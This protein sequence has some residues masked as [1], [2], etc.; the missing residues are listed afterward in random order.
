[1]RF[2]IYQDITN[3]WRWRIREADNKTVAVSNETYKDKQD[4]L[5]VINLIKANATNLT[6]VELCHVGEQQP[7]EPSVK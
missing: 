5:N 1:M 7:V 6:V 2:E 4:C 3:C